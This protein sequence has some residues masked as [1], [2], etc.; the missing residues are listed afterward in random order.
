MEV[1]TNSNKQ[2]TIADNLTLTGAPTLTSVKAKM[3]A[4]NPASN[5]T[6]TIKVSG[7]TSQINDFVIEKTRASEFT[8]CALPTIY[9]DYNS[10]SLDLDGATTNDI[11]NVKATI[12]KTLKELFYGTDGSDGY[13][14]NCDL[15]NYSIKN[16]RHTD[17]NIAQPEEIN[18]EGSDAKRYAISLADDTLLDG[19][20]QGYINNFGGRKPQIEAVPQPTEIELSDVLKIFFATTSKNVAGNVFGPFPDVV[21]PLTSESTDNASTEIKTN[22][23]SDSNPLKLS[24]G[25]AGTDLLLSGNNIGLTKG[26][27]LYYNLKNVTFVSENSVTPIDYSN[28]NGS[29]VSMNFSDSAEGAEKNFLLS[30][31]PK[32]AVTQK[33]VV[34]IGAN[35]TL[36][37]DNNSGTY[38]FSTLNM[39]P[40]SKLVVQSGAIVNM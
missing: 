31:M 3:Y 5:N 10:S 13:L 33:L 12:Q 9:L 22:I 17:P 39:K 6:I 20:I 37:L 15:K 32:L 11:G 24:G 16:Y 21:M 38:N 26:I 40:G 25:E 1:A 34:S 19:T 7:L 14:L 2:L 27:E 35:S 4:S 23:V 18:I 8:G 29:A 28:S 30:A 36:T